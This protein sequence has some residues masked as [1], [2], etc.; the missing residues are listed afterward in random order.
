MRV[1]FL[2]WEDPLEKEMVTRS[3]ILAWDIPWT[4]GRLQPTGSHSRIESDTTEVSQHMREVN[5]NNIFT[6]KK[7]K[8]IERDV[9]GLIVTKCYKAQSGTISQCGSLNYGIQNQVSTP[10]G[11]CHKQHLVS[12]KMNQKLSQN[13][14]QQQLPLLGLQEPLRQ[15]VTVTLGAL[16]DDS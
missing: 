11:Y 3:S 13:L 7:K 2:G 6:K 8:K 9:N 4:A 1:Q 14:P 16:S 15:S 5:L 10:A 12:W